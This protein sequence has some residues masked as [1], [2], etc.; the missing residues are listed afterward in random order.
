VSQSNNLVLWD[1]SGTPHAFSVRG[2][3]SLAGKYGGLA[4]T[5]ESGD[6]LSLPTNPGVLGFDLDDSQYQHGLSTQL[7][8]DDF[9]QYRKDFPSHLLEKTVKP[10]VGLRPVTKI[11][12]SKSRASL[13][14]NGQT[15][16]TGTK[17]ST[18]HT[19]D[20]EEVP[21]W[22]PWLP[23]KSQ[24]MCLKVKELRAACK[25]RGL[26]QSG[27]KDLLQQRLLIWAATRDK[28][29]VEDRLLGLKDLVA[30]AKQ[31]KDGEAKTNLE[32]D[33]EL[34]TSKRKAMTA[35]ANK[36]K[37]DK[38]KGILG[39]VDQSYFDPQQSNEL[40]TSDEEDDEIDPIVNE[41]SVAQLSRSFRIPTK[42]SNHELREMYMQAKFADQNGD[43]EGSKSLLRELRE[44]TPHDMRVVR[45]LARMEQEDGNLATAR[46]LLQQALRK[47]PN[48]AH[49]LQGLGQLERQV[50]NDS[51]A[52]QYYQKAIESN[53]SL[54]NSYHALGTLEHN[55]GNIK[56]ALSVIKEGLKHSPN[57]HRLHHALGDIYMDAQMFDMAENSY[58]SA[59]QNV[60]REWGKAFIYTY[61]SFVAYSKGDIEDCRALLRRSLDVN[62]GM[63]AQGVIALAQLEESEGNI[64]DA[65]KVYRDSIN[66]YE[67]KRSRRGSGNSESSLLKRE[68]DPFDNS[69]VNG[70][71]S[72]HSMSYSGDKWINVFR[73]W[74]RMESI[75]GSYET[76]HI[77]FSWGARL[78]PESTA[79]L[80]EWAQLQVEHNYDDKAKLLFEAACQRVSGR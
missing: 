27:K 64:N 40:A 5:K 51:V 46:M 67:K 73:S 6:S 32:Y 80:T 79:L 26:L 45:R 22:L 10:K 12:P 62:G 24:I 48:N 69:F 34:L 61:L 14:R 3:S 66:R 25:E 20:K 50:G 78:F 59:F 65:R 35:D 57:N 21:P 1:R 30:G 17:R 2:L 47:E 8:L 29:R 49:L 56:T 60:E 31:S 33:V 42:Y 36:E 43:R 16:T 71:E 19:D 70:L 41:E 74:A 44:A 52:I 75:H 28:K 39:L 38:K 54:P 68:V 55:R 11:R 9:E 37:P 4:S 76:A 58:L 53:P 63:H 77:V 72:Q 13:L 23:T 18:K 15:T 7:P